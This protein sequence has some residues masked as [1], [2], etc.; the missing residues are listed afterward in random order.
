MIVDNKDFQEQL[1]ILKEG[2]DIPQLDPSK[3][4]DSEEFNI[5]FNG[6]EV[7]L[8]NITQNIRVLEDANDYLVKYV[9]DTIDK[10]YKDIND[11]LLNLEKNYSLYQ[12]K[13]FITYNVELDSSKDILDRTGNAISTVD[14]VTMQSGT[15]DLFKNISAVEPYSVDIDKEHRSAV[16]CFSKNAITQNN[17]K[18][19]TFIIKLLEPIT[20]NIVTCNLIN[21]VG[22]FTINNSIQEYQ[23]NSYFKPQEV[24]LIVVTL[25]SGNPSTESKSVRVNHSKGFMDND[26]YGDFSISQN[27]EK[28]KEQQMAEIY[29][30]NDVTKY[31]GEND[32]RRN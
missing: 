27:S 25:K 3:I 6:V 17:T 18:V 16:I 10:K 29:Y 20:I 24:S 30:K 15:I 2:I 13:N 32:G 9:N 23:F 26:F 22:S 1:N 5:F 7:A 12:D 14:Y 8:N 19:G 11:K 4:M 31:L 28:A 21:C